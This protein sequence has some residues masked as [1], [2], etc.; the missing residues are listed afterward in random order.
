LAQSCRPRPGRHDNQLIG[1]LTKAIGT[2]EVKQKLEIQGLY[3]E[4]TCG[5]DF[6]DLIRHR[7]EEYGEAIKQAG[8]K[9]E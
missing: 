2:P 6:A 4:L 5:S 9:T 1:W 8:L 3:P 7:Y